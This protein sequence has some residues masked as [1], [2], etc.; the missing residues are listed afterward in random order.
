M[1]TVNAAKAL[2]WDDQI[3]SLAVG[4]KADIVVVNPDTP[5]MLVRLRL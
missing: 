3:G 1:V 2:L 4:K 5:N